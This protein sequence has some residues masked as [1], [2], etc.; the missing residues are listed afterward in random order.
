MYRG[1]GTGL[2]GLGLVLV[3]VGAVLSWAVTVTTTGFNINTVG[4]ILLVVGIIS[5]IIGGAVFFAGS[6]RRA[7]SRESIQYTPSGRERVVEHQDVMP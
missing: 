7:V 6:N 3:V 4:V 2:I 5:V 1:A